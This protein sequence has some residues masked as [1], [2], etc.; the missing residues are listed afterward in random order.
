MPACRRRQGAHGTVGL[1]LMRSY[2]LA[3]NTAHYDGVIRRSKRAAE[4]HPGLRIGP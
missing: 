3:G 2:L 1:I 4:G